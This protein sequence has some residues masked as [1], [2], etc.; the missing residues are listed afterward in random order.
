VSENGADFRPGDEDTGLEPLGRKQ[1]ARG[2]G[3]SMRAVFDVL[4]EAGE[5]LDVDTIAERTFDRVDAPSHYHAR[6]AYVRQRE[7]HRRW[8]HRRRDIHTSAALSPEEISAISL[9]DAWRFWLRKLLDNSGA[10]TGVL[11]R[12]GER[13]QRR[14]EPNPAKPPRVQR[15]DGRLVRYTR[16]E[17]LGL[18]AEEKAIGDVFAMREAIGRHLGGLSETELRQMVELAATKFAP[19]EG[20]TNVRT[21]RARV[22]WLLDRPS[23]DAGRAWLLRELV[24]RAYGDPPAST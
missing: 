7:A 11:I 24:R 14:Y 9:A 18:S 1:A 16:E 13:G 21:L 22:R 17:A 2:I 20:R 4:Y 23:T 5:P 12:S 8:D 10:G 19:D 3:P 6:R 15:A